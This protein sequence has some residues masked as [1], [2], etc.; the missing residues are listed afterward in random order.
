[1]KNWKTT[2]LGI[3]SIIAGIISIVFVAIDKATLTEAGAYL[4]LVLAFV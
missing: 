2:T 3:F 1:M 4:A